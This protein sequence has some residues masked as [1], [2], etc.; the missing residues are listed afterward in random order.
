[1]NMFAAAKPVADKPKTSKAKAKTQIETKDVELFCALK[2]V[3][4]SVKAQ[5]AVIEA[6]LKSTI[7]ER[8]VI[9]GIRTGKKPES[10]EGVEND[11]TCSLQLRMRSSASGLSDEEIELLNEHNIPFTENVSVEPC[12]RINPAYSDMSDAKN[13]EM[14]AKVSEALEGL[15]LPADFIERQNKVAKTI[16]TEDSIT[17]VCKLT[18][19][20]GKLK[21][22]ADE[23]TIAAL[24]PLVTVPAIRPTLAAGKNPFQIV[25]AALGEL[26]VV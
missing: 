11:S 16:A 21:G 13:A 15:G 9:E 8:A 22:K 19:K 17:A 2:A 14:L 26:A 6:G 7:F 4:T 3:E 5:I 23:A 10:H 20:A 1:M 25:D 24:L 18:H 12:F